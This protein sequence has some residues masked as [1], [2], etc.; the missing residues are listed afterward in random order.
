MPQPTASPRARPPSV[1]RLVAAA[2]PCLTG[3]REHEALVVAARAA[4][5]AERA[6]MGQGAVARPL[7]ALAGKVVGLLDGEVDPLGAEG[8]GDTASTGVINATRVIPHT[9]LGRGQRAAA[10]GDGS[11]VGAARRPVPAC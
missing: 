8:R 11:G 6:R 3:E 4:I 10:A 9:D 1:E 5:N 7:A 2:R